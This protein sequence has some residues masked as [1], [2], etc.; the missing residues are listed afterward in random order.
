MRRMTFLAAVACLLIGGAAQAASSAGHSYSVECNEHGFVLR[1]NYPV[2]R[3]ARGGFHDM[4]KLDPEIIYLGKDCD[5]FHKDLGW[6]GKWG[7]ANGGVRINFENT[8]SSFG[9]YGQFQPDMIGFPRADIGVWADQCPRDLDL[10]NC[11]P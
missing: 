3:W 7:W 6:R 2:F 10:T 9:Y 5:V 8:V 4:R 11:R 1:S